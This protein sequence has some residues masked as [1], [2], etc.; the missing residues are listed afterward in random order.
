MQDF[1]LSTFACNFALLYTLA[2]TNL[3]IEIL[4]ALEGMGPPWTRSVFAV[5]FSACFLPPFTSAGCCHPE[6]LACL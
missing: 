5:L 4:D 2:D 6:V 3:Q 1:K